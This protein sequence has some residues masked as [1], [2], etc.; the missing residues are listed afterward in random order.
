MKV[1]VESPLIDE[2]ADERKCRMSEPSV[3]ISEMQASRLSVVVSRLD[4]RRH[5]SRYL[6]SRHSQ[7]PL[8][9]PTPTLRV[10]AARGLAGL[11]VQTG[12]R[13]GAASSCVRTAARA[14]RVADST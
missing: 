13:C 4:Y 14:T 10:Q 12:T 2:L 11:P 5:R 7:E 9:A 1:R 8:A 6:L 3:L